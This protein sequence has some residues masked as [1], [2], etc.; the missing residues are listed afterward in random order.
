M[1]Y[2]Y[3]L[4]YTGGHDL[5]DTP[6]EAQRLFEEY[7]TSDETPRVVALTGFTDVTGEFE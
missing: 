7:N 1:T 6:E 5:V 3:A 4:F 2:L